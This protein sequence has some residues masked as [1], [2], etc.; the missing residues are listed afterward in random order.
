M[1]IPAR[2]VLLVFVVT[3]SLSSSGC[4]PRSTA[5]SP[6]VEG[7]VIDSRTK[8][9]VERANVYLRERPDT[10]TITDSDEHFALKAHTG[11]RLIFV[12]GDPICSGMLVVEKAGYHS[13]EAQ[14]RVM[15]NQV[16]RIAVE[17]SAKP[18]P[19]P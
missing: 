1:T 14:V 9:S 12:M 7:S 17:L 2:G 10:R 8:C 3:A 4:L 11:L 16:A 13:K 5:V 15:N 19:L 6:A 18:D